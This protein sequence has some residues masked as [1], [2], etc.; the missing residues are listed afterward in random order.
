MNSSTKEPQSNE[1]IEAKQTIQ[2]L[3]HKTSNNNKIRR[4]LEFLGIN[5]DSL[6]LDEVKE[7]IKDVQGN[8]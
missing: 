5:D 6:D 7:T 8:S 3:K 1:H 4:Y 2:N